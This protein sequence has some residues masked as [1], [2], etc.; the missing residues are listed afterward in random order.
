MLTPLLVRDLEKYIYPFYLLIFI[1]PAPGDYS[2][3]NTQ[4]VFTV[5]A[6]TGAMECASLQVIN[7]NVVEEDEET[8]ILTMSAD[9]PPV[10]ITTALLATVTIREMDNDGKLR[11]AYILCF[12][13]IKRSFVFYYILLD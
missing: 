13:H 10:T 2:E 5:G 7:D 9:D 12:S 11:D 6:S 1:N 8:L 3:L 4:V